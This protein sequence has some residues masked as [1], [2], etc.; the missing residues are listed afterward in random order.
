LTKYVRYVYALK[1]KYVCWT[2]IQ[3]LFFGM[4]YVLTA[5]TIH[6]VCDC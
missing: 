3:F 6:N 1:I 4:L 5:E 2:Q